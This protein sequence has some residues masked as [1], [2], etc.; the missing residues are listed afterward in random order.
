MQQGPLA[1]DCCRSIL[2]PPPGAASHLPMC[3]PRLQDVHV[4]CAS[5]GAGIGPRASCEPLTVT[6]VALGARSAR[7]A[8]ALLP[9][10]RAPSGPTQVEPSGWTCCDRA[11]QPTQGGLGG[12]CAV[13]LRSSR[14]S[15]LVL[16]CSCAEDWALL[17]SRGEGGGSA[18]AVVMTGHEIQGTQRDASLPA[19]GSCGMLVAIM[20]TIC[21]VYCMH[22][23]EVCNEGCTGSN[24][25][26]N[27]AA[28]WQ[29]QVA[30]AHT[31][32]QC[33]FCPLKAGTLEAGIAGWRTPR[34]LRRLACG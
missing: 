13:G 28:P 18:S 31:V 9:H 21:R 1:G 26:G 4:H 22:M 8:S 16:A 27:L 15:N 3:L 14:L 30:V 34:R 20:S 5:A 10:A 29:R 33:P 25:P 17:L 7:L 6:M 19:F 12:R 2:T 24:A 11:A 32:S 23:L